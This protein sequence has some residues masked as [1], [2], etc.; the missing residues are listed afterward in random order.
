[1]LFCL[2]AIA[3]PDTVYLKNGTTVDGEIIG[4][5]DII[6]KIFLVRFQRA[7]V[8]EKSQVD[9]VER[10]GEIYTFDNLTL[11]SAQF[12]PRF[13]VAPKRIREA[14]RERPDPIFA[15]DIFKTLDLQNTDSLVTARKAMN[16]FFNAP[17]RWGSVG[18]GFLYAS[19]L[20][21]DDPGKFDGYDFAFNRRHFG[22]RCL[23]AQIRRNFPG[24]WGTVIVDVGYGKND[25]ETAEFGEVK[26]A[27]VMRYFTAR[28]VF[29]RNQWLLSPGLSG[30]FSVMKAGIIRYD[31]MEKGDPDSTRRQVDLSLYRT[32]FRPLVGIDLNFYDVV[33]ASLSADLLRLPEMGLYF[34]LA[35]LMPF[36]Q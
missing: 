8:V 12:N 26:E 17:S 25:I 19:D 33:S 10:D 35:F 21:P 23:N 4:K 9:S 1:M 20:K 31:A 14:V 7:V 3:V 2:C 32:S 5:S 18:F 6:L 16:L 29:C 36:V 24:G 11:K 22:L 13:R 15:E 27:A 34:S 28:Y 30:G